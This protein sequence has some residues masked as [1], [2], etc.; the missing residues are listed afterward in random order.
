MLFYSLLS[1][2]SFQFQK[3]F[4]KERVISDSVNTDLFYDSLKVEVIMHFRAASR[5]IF[6]IS[7]LILFATKVAKTKIFYL[8]E[9]II[10]KYRKTF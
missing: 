7:F 1:L 9:K 3:R 6:N 4:S 8:E 5:I 2:S 10:Y